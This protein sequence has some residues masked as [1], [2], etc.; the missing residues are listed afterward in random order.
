MFITERRSETLINGTLRSLIN[1]QCSV[2]IFNSKMK[3]S[4]YALIKGLYCTVIKDC[5]FIRDIRVGNGI[6]KVIRSNFYATFCITWK[7][8]FLH[9]ELNNKPIKEILCFCTYCVLSPLTESN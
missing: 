3:S 7:D 6:Y 8:T 5:T 2:R 1:V 9:I 4:L